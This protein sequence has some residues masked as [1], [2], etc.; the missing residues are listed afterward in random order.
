MLLGCIADDLTGA[1]DLANNLARSGMRV[2]LRVGIPS[3]AA[4]DVD[5]IVVSLKSRTAPVDEAVAES[6]A[7]ARW[8]VSQG[9]RQIYFK[10]CSTFDSTPQGNIGPVA[11][12]LADL[13]GAR[14]IAVTP[15]FPAG[16]RTVYLGH[17]FVGTALL[18]DSP[19]RSHPLTPMMD[20]N[21]Q[22]VLQ[23]QLRSSRVG[24][25]DLPTVAR[26]PLALRERLDSLA[27]AG[28][29]FAIVDAV[30]D[31]HLIALGSAIA[32]LPLVVAASGLGVGL[33]RAHGFVAGQ[34]GALPRPSGARAIVSGSC[35]AA[36]QAQVADFIRRGG[37]AFEVDACA[38]SID[39]EVSR[40]VALS[41]P[42]LG[43]APVLVFSTADTARV[44]AV[45]QQFGHAAAA[46]RIE[47]MLAGIARAL[48]E[49][50]VGQ[51]VVAGGE[52]SGACIQRLGLHA[53]RI[54]RQVDPGVPWCFSDAARLHI[55]LKSGN[56]GSEDFFSKAFDLLGEGV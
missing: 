32:D 22:R 43:D 30:D 31:S 9:A 52:T 44:N 8:L 28:M 21:L 11:E 48:V 34:V 51:L 29:R 23:P 6:L 12:A 35:S 54:G 38:T 55:C 56:F 49:C 18:S 10:I 42:L 27:S 2:A 45:Q 36:S 17:L 20:A 24:L 1:S 37:L 41:K 19:M 40:V 53:L 39:D 7:A 46:Q 47:Y 5:A 13:L 25:V 3:G 26:G 33:P 50:G 16:G 4:D 14:A 15:A